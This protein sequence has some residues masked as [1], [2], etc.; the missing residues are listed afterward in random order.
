MATTTIS[1][2]VIWTKHIHGDPELT[3]RIHALWA[4]ETIELEVDGVRG[5]W[6]KMD[7]GADGR[8]TPG[9]RPIGA[10]Q[11]VWRSLYKRRRGEAV[12]LRALEARGGVSETAP[13]EARS[14]LLFPPLGKTEEE[15]RAA[16]RSF[17]DFA[18]LGY[19]SE[20]PYGPRDELYDRE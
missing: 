20:G 11:V 8:T 7:D 13:D 6:R 19:R 15:R 9:I 10:M 3:G 14:R 18:K 2:F 1:D 17:L 12:S 4:G 5:V 16:L